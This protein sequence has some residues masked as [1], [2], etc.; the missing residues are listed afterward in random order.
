MASTKGMRMKKIINK[1]IQN[2]MD[3]KKIITKITIQKYI[4]QIINIRV[5]M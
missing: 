5:N 3:S 2:K 4:N 1:D